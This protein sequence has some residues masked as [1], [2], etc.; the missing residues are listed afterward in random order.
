MSDWRIK[1]K[2][3]TFNIK[4]GRRC[5]ARVQKK[6]GALEDARKLSAADDMLIALQR[7]MGSVNHS[8]CWDAE[9][10]AMGEAAIAKALGKK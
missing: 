3:D 10:W 4:S 9:A 1:E 7:I 5:I 6:A 8:M 2:V